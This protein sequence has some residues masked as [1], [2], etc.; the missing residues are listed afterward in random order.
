MEYAL[1]EDKRE[2]RDM[3]WQRLLAAAVLAVVAMI[4]MTALSL[5]FS[6]SGNVAH[7]A[8]AKSNNLIPVPGTRTCTCLFL[9]TVTQF[10]ESGPCP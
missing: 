2:A 9:N 10:N 5:P 3:L 6:A 1:L 7:A 8:A 4:L